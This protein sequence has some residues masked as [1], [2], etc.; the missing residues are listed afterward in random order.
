MCELFA[1]ARLVFLNRDASVLHR[2]SIDR[3]C[4]SICT[5]GS[6][7]WVGRVPRPP[8]GHQRHILKLRVFFKRAGFAHN[9]LEHTDNVVDRAEAL[10]NDKQ[11]GTLVSH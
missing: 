2:V 6:G 5:R 9:F 8:S 4:I 10:M 11:A 3:F 7:K 1:L